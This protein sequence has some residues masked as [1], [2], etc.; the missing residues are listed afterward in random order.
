MLTE[1]NWNYFTPEN[2]ADYMVEIQ[3]SAL[4]DYISSTPTLPFIVAQINV[5]LNETR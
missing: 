3:R 4:K 1:E 5:E 2:Y